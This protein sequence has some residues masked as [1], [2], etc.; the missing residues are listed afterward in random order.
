MHTGGPTAL[1]KKMIRHHRGRASLKERA[2]KKS[3]AWRRLTKKEN[4]AGLRRAESPG[5]EG[6]MTHDLHSTTSLKTMKARSMFPD[7]GIRQTERSKNGKGFKGRGG[8][9]IKNFGQ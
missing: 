8:E 7:I 4:G 3:R 1:M 5:G 6:E 9:N 2:L